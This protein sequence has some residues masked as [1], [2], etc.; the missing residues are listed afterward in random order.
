[1]SQLNIKSKKKKQYLPIIF[2]LEIEKISDNIK[3]YYFTFSR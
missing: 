1:M 3:Y 2:V